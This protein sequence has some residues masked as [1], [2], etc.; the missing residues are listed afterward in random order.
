MKFLKFGMRRLGLVALATALTLGMLGFTPASA[1]P[2]VLYF[3]N[4]PNIA[5][6]YPWLS[7]PT[8][9][10]SSALYNAG[11][12]QFIAGTGPPNSAWN[13][14]AYFVML[15]ALVAGPVSLGNSAVTD[16]VALSNTV[17]FSAT[18][19]AKL[20]D[21]AP[22][23]AKTLLGQDA[24]V[25]SVLSTGPV[26]L[27][28]HMTLTNPTVAATH[29]LALRVDL[30]NTTSAGAGYAIVYDFA[31]A[32][33]NVTITFSAPTTTTTTSHSTSCTGMGCTPPP[34]P[35]GISGY[36]ACSTSTSSSNSAGG[37]ATTG[38][39]GSFWYAAAVGTVIIVTAL[40]VVA[41]SRRTT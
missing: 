39:I 26:E 23:G 16:V 20:Y 22:G 29:G 8:F 14:S 11:G 5:P 31:I 12:P 28:S 35:C 30:V 36:P 15:P 18:F 10:N 32:N 25:V 24:S 38:G 33:S 13:A 27:T 9:M 34:P 19:T 21:V 2:T 17:T 6:P 37:L 41:R 7:T 1:A 4:D 40:L 3:H